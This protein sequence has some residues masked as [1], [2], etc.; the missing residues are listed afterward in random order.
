MEG[1][2]KLSLPV[3]PLGVATR[4][5]NMKTLLTIVL[6][7]ASVVLSAAAPPDKAAEEWDVREA[8]FRHQFGKNASALQ[9]R[10]GAYCLSVRGENLKDADPPADFMKRF[11]GNIPP[12]KK[13]SDCVLTDRGVVDRRT[14]EPGLIFRTGVIKSMSDTEAEISGGYSEHNRS[15][16]GNTYYLKK[17]DG[18]WKVIKDVLN[19]L[20]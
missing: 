18:R 12:V 7:F 10:A 16:S 14:G 15:G 5:D 3:E 17:V 19:W 2:P 4:V 1:G 11:D 8:T 13:V 20:F 6:A 9:Q